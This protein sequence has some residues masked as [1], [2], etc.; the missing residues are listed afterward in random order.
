MVSFDFKSE[1]R[2]NLQMHFLPPCSQPISQWQPH[3]EEENKF[4]E[5]LFETKDEVISLEKEAT[6]QVTCNKWIFFT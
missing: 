4:F 5:N 1:I 3:T 6:K 2:F